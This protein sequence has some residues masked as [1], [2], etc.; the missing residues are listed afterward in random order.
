ME[1][2][3]N[4]NEGVKELKENQFIINKNKIILKTEY[5][6]NLNGIFRLPCV[7]GYW[8]ITP[9]VVSSKSLFFNVLISTTKE[10]LNIN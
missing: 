9:S 2:I 8:N 10:L 4:R 1:N 7:S 6:N 5:T 3:Y